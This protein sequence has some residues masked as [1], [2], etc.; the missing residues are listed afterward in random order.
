MDCCA[1]TVVIGTLLGSF[2]VKL[3]VAIALEI[4]V[5]GCVGRRGGRAV[6]QNKNSYNVTLQNKLS[7]LIF[8]S[9]LASYTWSYTLMITMKNVIT[10]QVDYLWRSQYCYYQYCCKGEGENVLTYYMNLHRR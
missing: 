6:I 3:S 5:V 2:V 1:G 7:S 4:K 9:S 8:C 10:Y